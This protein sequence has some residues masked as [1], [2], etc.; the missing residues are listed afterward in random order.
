M[1]LFFRRKKK[2]EQ[3]ESLKKELNEKI[4]SERNKFNSR[5]EIE[6]EL[7][8]IRSN[9]PKDNVDHYSESAM[10][11][12]RSFDYKDIGK[13]FDVL[14]DPFIDSLGEVSNENAFDNFVKEIEET[15]DSDDNKGGENKGNKND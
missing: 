2:K 13:K 3:L 8:K 1:G 5:D 11:Y 10:C 9:E 14:I 4:E 15:S 12:C 7:E 6:K